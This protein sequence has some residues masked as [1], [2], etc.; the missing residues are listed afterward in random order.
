MAKSVIANRGMGSGFWTLWTATAFSNLGDGIIKFLL[1][2][3]AAKTTSSPA[4]VAGVSFMATL[5][6]LLFSLPIGAIVDRVDRKKLITLINLFRVS[7]V[8]TLFL[9]AAGGWLHIYVLYLLAVVLGVCETFS[10]T[11]SGSLVPSVVPRDR[12]EQANARIFSVETI[13]N[14]FVGGPL[15]GFFI[16]IS[17]SMTVLSGS[18]TYLMTIIVLLFLRGDFK[19][20][21]T[22]K[23][24][25]RKD[26]AEG[27]RFLWSNQ[28][29]R[30]LAIMVAVMSGCW[31]AFF[32][33]LVLHAVAPGPLQ[34]NEFGYSMLLTALA[35]GSLAGAAMV[36]PIQKILG[37]R[38]L[39]G[40]DVVGTI[41]MLAVPALTS[42]VWLVGAAI[43]LGGFGGATWSV[44]VATIRQNLIPDELLG[45]VY[46]AYRL[47]GWGTLSLGAI[48]AGMIAEVASVPV[49]FL[50]GALIN[51]ALFI[52]MI[53]VLTKE[54]LDEARLEA[55]TI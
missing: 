32:S 49:V 33:L 40:I 3:L 50:G 44:G 21:R 28:I 24:S 27:V 36:G 11:A 35:A 47:V 15:A 53:T 42:N 43:F 17:I 22:S 39:L 8:M 38:G 31:S 16:S 48:V 19:A 29:L 14:R 55:K 26:I 25:I 13:T 5:P 45:R 52:P 54:N 41:V 37:R 12:L 4:L 18:F 2:V 23:S 9:A 6:W 30:T 46:A 1:P 10:D 20:A 34:L 7:V 51:L